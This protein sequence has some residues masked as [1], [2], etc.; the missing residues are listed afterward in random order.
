M[1]NKYLDEF[2]KLENDIL[3]LNQL[4][5]NLTNKNLIMQNKIKIN[6]KNILKKKLLNNKQIGGSNMIYKINYSLQNL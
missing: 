4:N 3:L 6:H 1:Q 5:N 2:N